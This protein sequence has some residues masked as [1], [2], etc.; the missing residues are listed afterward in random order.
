MKELV[1]LYEALDRPEEAAKWRKERDCSTCHHGTMTVWAFSEA[2][3]RGYDVPADV[4]ADVTKWTKDRL[5][6][7]IDLPEN[8]NWQLNA[9]R[10]AWL[11]VIEGRAQ[12]GLVNAFVGEAIFVEA[13]HAGLK[14]GSG[15]LKGLL[16]YPGPTPIRGLLQDLDQT[17]ARFPA[18]TRPSGH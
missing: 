11:L 7:R 10:E 16:A 9:E 15:G 13:D 14:A 6:E 17:S 2:K 4:R 8:S 5:L 12:I 3:S 1:R 18:P